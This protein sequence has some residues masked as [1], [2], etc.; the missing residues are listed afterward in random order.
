MDSDAIAMKV[1]SS[2][3]RK[4]EACIMNGQANGPSCA[5]LKA[6]ADPSTSIHPWGQKA[7]THHSHYIRGI[8]SWQSIF[9]PALFLPEICYFPDC[10]LNLIL[11]LCSNSLF[12]S[13][14][15][16]SQFASRCCASHYLCFSSRSKPF[17]SFAGCWV[18]PFHTTS[19][20]S[21]WFSRTAAVNRKQSPC[22]W[23]FFMAFLIG[24]YMLLCEQ[25]WFWC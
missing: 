22:L 17:K 4:W 24:K 6:K 15:F 19:A 23:F 12:F 10:S 20:F 14:V 1:S 18:S 2:K 7:T 16:R 21:V 25:K 11:S 5:S 13:I 8:R 3:D 9:Y